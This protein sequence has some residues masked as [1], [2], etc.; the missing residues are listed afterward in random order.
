[1]FVEPIAAEF[2]RH[3]PPELERFAYHWHIGVRALWSF[4]LLRTHHGT[5]EETL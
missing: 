1:V 2:I 3:V 5:S 4:K